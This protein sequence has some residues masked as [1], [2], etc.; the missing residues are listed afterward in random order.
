M[1]SLDSQSC[2]TLKNQD[3]GPKSDR[4][5]RKNTNSPIRKSTKNIIRNAQ[6]L[7][8]ITQMQ[9]NITDQIKDMD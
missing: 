3:Q 4:E 8:I 7:S 2:P 9:M 5:V 1:K 6:T